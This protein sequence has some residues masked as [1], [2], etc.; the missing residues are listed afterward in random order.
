[1]GSVLGWGPVDGVNLPSLGI[2][3]LGSIVLLII[4][5]MVRR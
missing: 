4:Y 1:M 2:A 5:R 3:I